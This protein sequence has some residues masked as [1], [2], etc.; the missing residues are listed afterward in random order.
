MKQTKF[1]SLMFEE[2]QCI[3]VY[4]LKRIIFTAH[5]EENKALI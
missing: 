1:Y 2:Y 5:P 4:I 3:K